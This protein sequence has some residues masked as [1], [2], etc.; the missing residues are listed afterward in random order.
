M[1]LIIELIEEL[2]RLAGIMGVV[3][4]RKL[5]EFAWELRGGDGS[6]ALR[7]E[8]GKGGEKRGV[9]WEGGELGF[10]E[11]GSCVDAGTRN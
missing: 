11:E 9:G 5:V 7:A 4:F 8:G 1:L 10:W 2:F 3:R 6:V